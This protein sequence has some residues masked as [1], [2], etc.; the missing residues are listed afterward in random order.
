MSRSRETRVH[1]CRYAPGTP[2]AQAG[3]SSIHWSRVAA[4]GQSPELGSPFDWRRAGAG[5][6]WRV[7]WSSLCWHRPIDQE[8]RRRRPASSSYPRMGRA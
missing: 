8:R 7:A 4:E 2:T 5:G 1:G 3:R 6:R